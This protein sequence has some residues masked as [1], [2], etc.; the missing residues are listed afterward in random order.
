MVESKKYINNFAFEQNL[1]S[2]AELFGSTF[3]H[4]NTCLLYVK[5]YISFNI[6][7][8]GDKKLSYVYFVELDI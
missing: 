2:T 5:Q 4:Q 3:I 8:I 6:S 1:A 7:N